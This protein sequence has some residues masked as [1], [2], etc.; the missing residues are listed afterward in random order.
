MRKTKTANSTDGGRINPNFE[1]TGYER[2]VLA[3][4]VNFASSVRDPECAPW[5]ACFFTEYTKTRTLPHGDIIEL[6][7]E[8]I[9]IALGGDQLSPKEL[10]ARQ[11][12]R[13][14]NRL[15]RRAVV[16]D[17]L[18]RSGYVPTLDELAA[19]EKRAAEFEEEVRQFREECRRNRERIAK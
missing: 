19:Y 17:V 12:R 8:G 16:D 1:L 6:F 4:V 18:R 9:D 15:R 13:E 3:N 7:S 10:Q 2:Q 5:V 11:E 14:R